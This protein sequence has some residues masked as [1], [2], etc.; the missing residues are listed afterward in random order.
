LKVKLENVY[1]LMS[2]EYCDIALS[3]IREAEKVYNQRITT[4]YGFLEK[5][6]FRLWH[7]W[8]INGLEP[9]SW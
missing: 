3:E 1:W 4:T 8:I 6:D 7:V 9:L 5:Y 2:K